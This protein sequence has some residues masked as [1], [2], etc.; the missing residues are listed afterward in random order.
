M[1]Q[2][3]NPPVAMTADRYSYPID[4]RGGQQVAA[5]QL[6]GVE[7]GTP[8]GTFKFQVSED[9]NV[10]NDLARGI[11]G[12]SAE[13]AKWTT[14]TLPATA[15]IH[16]LSAAFTITLPDDEIAY[17]G[18]LALN[19]WIAFSCPARRVRCWFDYSSGGGAAA[20]LTI[21]AGDDGV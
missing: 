9:M 10:E 20:L 18:T 14:V 12:T 3:K 6:I 8:V 21:Y 7:T 4:C 5:F 17:D 13:T 11:Y 15:I 16:G 1:T 19:A 2:Y